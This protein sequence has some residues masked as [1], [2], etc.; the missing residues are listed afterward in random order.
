[1]TQDAPLGR[2]RINYSWARA[3]SEVAAIPDVP[4]RSW[5]P[6]QDVREREVGRGGVGGVGVGRSQYVVT[7]CVRV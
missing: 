3:E 2:Y 7:P 5:S 4:L 6:G 1:M